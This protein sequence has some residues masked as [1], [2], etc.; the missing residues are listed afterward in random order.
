MTSASVFKKKK[1]NCVDTSIQKI[2]FKIMKTFF[3][4][5][6]LTDISAKEEELTLTLNKFSFIVKTDHFGVNLAT[7]WL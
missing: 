1:K 4:W 3:F 6:E 7:Y 5:V 2:F